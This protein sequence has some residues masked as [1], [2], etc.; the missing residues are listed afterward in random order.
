MAYLKDISAVLG[1]SVSTVSKALKGYSD[2]SE[3]TRK[4]VIRA[5]EEL[6]YSYRGEKNPCAVR[7]AGGAVAVMMPGFAGRMHELYYR[8]MVCA[9]AAEAARSRRD[10][11]IMGEDDA[12]QEMSWVG[13]A[14]ARRVDGICLLVSREDLYN[15][16]FAD[17]L[18]SGLPLVSVENDIV[19]HASVCMDFRGEAEAVMKYLKEKGH[20]RT[21]YLGDLSLDSKQYAYILEEEAQKLDMGLVKMNSEMMENDE[22]LCQPDGG[23]ITCIIFTSRTAAVHWM[24]RWKERGMRLAEDVSVVVV[25]TSHGAPETFTDGFETSRAR[26]GGD[27]I[28]CVRE[29]PAD[30]GRESIRRLISIME[31][32]EM[33]KKETAP[34]IGIIFE[35]NT[36]KDLSG[37]SARNF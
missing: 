13:R 24:E 16:R 22:A 15:G 20:H 33:G 32:P 30:M 34:V 11:V 29:S 3:D 9:M 26:E 35:G 36:V 37:K 14:A 7:R 25:E 5:A 23:G 28:T 1:V 10:L 18:K 31:H 12:E 6:D 8:E 27:D 19:G 2:I 4:K 17:V 21:A